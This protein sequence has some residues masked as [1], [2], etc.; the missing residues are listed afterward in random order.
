MRYVTLPEILHLHRRVIEQSRAVS[1]SVSEGTFPSA[2]ALE[3]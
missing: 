1:R 2:Y 3:P